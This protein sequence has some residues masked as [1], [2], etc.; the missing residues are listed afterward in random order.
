VATLFGAL[1]TA[2][3]AYITIY[4]RLRENKAFLIRDTSDK[5][6][7][8]DMAC[9]YQIVFLGTSHKRLSVYLEQLQQV[10]KCSQLRSIQVFYASEQS[11]KAVEGSDFFANMVESRHR[12]S[13]LIATSDWRHQ[14]PKFEYLSFYQSRYL[15]NFEGTIIGRGDDNWHT[16][17]I[18][19]NIAVAPF[20]AENTLTIRYKKNLPWF[21]RSRTNDVINF[22]TTA[23]QNIANRAQCL[24]IFKHSL[25]DDSV[26]EWSEFSGQCYAHLA[27]MEFLLDTAQLTGKEKVLDVAA[28]TG[29]VS[30]LIIDK[31]PTVKLSVL[32]AS[33]RIIEMCRTVL[34]HTARY[35]LCRVPENCID[36][37]NTYYDVILIHLSLPA[38]ARTLQELEKLAVWCRKYLAPNGKVILAAHNTAVDIPSDFLIDRDP[39][40]EALQNELE[41]MNLKYHE[42]AKKRFSPAE[43]NYAFENVGF[44]CIENKTK[45][46]RMDMEHRI[47]MWS[48]PAVLGEVTDVS[49]I[50]DKKRRYLIDRIRVKLDDQLLR[51]PL[52]NPQHHLL[53]PIERWWHDC[54]DRGGFENGEFSSFDGEGSE[55]V[56]FLSTDEAI[57]GIVYTAG[58]K[59]FKKPSANV[60]GCQMPALYAR[61]VGTRQ[62]SGGRRR[63]SLEGGNRGMRSGESGSATVYGDLNGRSALNLASK[64]IDW[65]VT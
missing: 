61:A 60:K 24:G 63:T 13:A 37:Q 34:H 28:G 53:A 59:M 55:W 62:N 19:E 35:A 45:S 50:S 14:F 16:I 20:V 22:Y 58:G 1:I 44:R 11:G 30:K 7:L 49:L 25:W 9:A 15:H 57:K 54:L 17:Y 21:F 4:L 33:P 29:H 64:P 32:D 65:A 10:S 51:P 3:P 12:I 8:H 5:D 56:E 23:Y 36:I 6:W 39:L 2:I 46:F 52:F 41:A 31:Y 18:V 40:R 48:A 47:T 26:Q 42:Y 38:L 43:I 27:S